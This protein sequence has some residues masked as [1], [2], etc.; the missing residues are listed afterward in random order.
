MQKRCFVFRRVHS[1]VHTVYSLSEVI[2]NEIFSLQHFS[3]AHSHL[4][5]NIRIRNKQ[6]LEN[7]YIHELR[8]IKSRNIGFRTLRG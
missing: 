7:S 5:D 2:K 6:M 4:L 8:C 1:L 3:P